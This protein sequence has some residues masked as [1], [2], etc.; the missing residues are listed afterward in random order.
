VAEAYVV[1][2]NT[3]TERCKHEEMCYNKVISREQCEMMSQ[4][5]AWH[6]D[7]DDM[8]EGV[9]YLSDVVKAAWG[10]DSPF[11]NDR[12]GV[13]WD[14]QKSLC[15]AWF[16]RED[17]TMEAFARMVPDCASIDFDVMEGTW[18]MHLPREF[19]KGEFE[20]EEKC[21][22]GVCD[23]DWGLDADECAETAKCDRHACWGCE[24]DWSIPEAHS[25]PHE[26]CYNSAI[27]Q[28]ECEANSWTDSDGE[29]V[30]GEEP[31]VWNAEFSVVSGVEGGHTEI[32]TPR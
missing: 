27:T 28:E 26:V 9:D 12:A 17:D 23:L 24:R 29:T 8:T 13:H 16:H 1:K 11:T 3:K 25:A 19:E 31:G 20:T 30:G 18:Q 21:S 7:N 2:W 10:T 5:A 15:R 22:S 6:V 14:E 32:L 4:Q